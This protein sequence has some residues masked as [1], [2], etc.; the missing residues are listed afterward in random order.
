MDRRLGAE[1]RV[2]H[3]V[4]RAHGATPGHTHELHRMVYARGPALTL[5][6]P[7][8]GGDRRRAQVVEQNDAI[9]GRILDA[10]LCV[11]PRR[12]SFMIAIDEDQVPAPV[13]L[14]RQLLYG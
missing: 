5:E 9:I 2:S 8:S 10:G 4:D 11:P 6:D 7:Q 1:T 12:F 3:V 13:L 14:V